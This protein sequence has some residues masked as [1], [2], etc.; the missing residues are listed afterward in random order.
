MPRIRSIR[1]E[2]WSDS[3]FVRLSLPARYLYMA[4]WTWADDEGRGRLIPKEIEGY[5]FPH[6]DLGAWNTS[7][8]KLLGELVRAKRI[9]PYDVGGDRFFYIPTFMR[10]QRPKAPTPSRL[11][12]PALSPPPGE[13]RHGDEKPLS[14]VPTTLSPVKTI[15]ATH[16]GKPVRVETEKQYDMFVRGTLAA[17]GYHDDNVGAQE[18]AR[19]ILN[20][21]MSWP[22]NPRSWTLNNLTKNWEKFSVD[23]VPVKPEVVA[24]QAARQQQTKRMKEW[25]NDQG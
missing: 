11:P 20:M 5:A 18:T 21:K 3:T 13:K 14:V 4:M 16:F 24:K 22:D 17:E 10:H 15:L 6:D 7:I 12:A 8:D 19:R 1:P 25:A 9:V 23:R 2:T